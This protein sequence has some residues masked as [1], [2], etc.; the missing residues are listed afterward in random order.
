M[1][2][3]VEDIIISAPESTISPQLCGNVLLAVCEHSKS[4]D[5]LYLALQPAEVE[6]SLVQSCVRKVFDGG[7]RI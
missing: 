7:F 1:Y 4:L 5:S 3:H 6:V 2:Q